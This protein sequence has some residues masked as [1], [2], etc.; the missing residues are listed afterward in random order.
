[1]FEVGREGNREGT[2]YTCYGEPL[3]YIGPIEESK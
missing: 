2:F 3:K 1:M